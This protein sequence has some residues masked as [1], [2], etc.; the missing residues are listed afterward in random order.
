MTNRL[1][2]TEVAHF[3]FITAAATWFL[4]LLVNPVGIWSSRHVL[5]WRERYA[6][7]P[8]LNKHILFYLGIAAIAVA[9]TVPVNLG[10][11][12]DSS[13]S[14]AVLIF[15]ITG[16]ILFQSFYQQLSSL[17]NILGSRLQYSLLIALGQILIFLSAC[18]IFFIEDR[19]IF[20]WF[21]FVFIGNALA[22]LLFVRVL[23]REFTGGMKHAPARELL[24]SREFMTFC[25]P[26]VA[27]TG[28]AWV[29]TQGYR[30]VIA[31]TGDLQRLALMGV[32]LG[33][34]AN[35]GGVLESLIQQYML[36]DFYKSIQQGSDISRELWRRMFTTVM[37]VL[38]IGCGGLFCFAPL[39][40][41]LL[42]SQSYVDG[43]RFLRW[44][45]GIEYFRILAN[46]VYFGYV[47][48]K[49]VHRAMPA[50]IAGAA[51]T[52]LFFALG[53]LFS[54]DLE[55]LILLGI[56]LG[57]IVNLLV[58]L[59]GMRQETRWRPPVKP[60][61]FAFLLCL[62]FA[63]GF[64]IPA[65]IGV[66]GIIGVL[67]VVGAYTLGITLILQRFLLKLR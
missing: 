54:A 31:S 61:A 55:V 41:R 57:V 28:A 42:T 40:L 26:I 12:L 48:E 52:I 39:I 49:R 37:V 46:F 56:L 11:G 66:P 65:S 15:G 32:G 17:Q 1:A 13:L 60:F 9:V 27:V 23:S 36:P 34:G 53:L 35:I 7:R 51:T 29:Q 2:Q 67:A 10:F 16:T 3:Y 59:W 47:G 43:Q 5:E 22:A 6:W 4:L 44:A 30:I 64:F 14:P 38:L 20:H 63:A 8:I 21:L 58:Q 19:D 18:G 45:A 62:P 33:L 24:P 50:F 25:L